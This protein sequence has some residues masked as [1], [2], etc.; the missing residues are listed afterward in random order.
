M[1]CYRL[2][3]YCLSVYGLEPSLFRFIF[4]RNQYKLSFIPSI[5]TMAVKKKIK[6]TI[7]SLGGSIIVPNHVDV[8]FLK[9]FRSFILDYL[10]DKER[11]LVLVCGGG[12]ICREYQEAAQQLASQQL[13]AQQSAS[14]TQTTAQRLVQLPSIKLSSE[15]L[16][17]IGIMSTRL[18]AELIRVLFKDVAYER[19]IYNPEERL[20]WI[21]MK[22]QLVIAAGYTPGWSTDYDAV[23]FAKELKA[24]MVINASNI[25]YVYDKDP[26]EFKEAKKVEKMSW[27]EYKT[28]VGGKFTPGMHAPFDPIASKVAS[29]EGIKVAVLHGQNLENMKKALRGK[30]FKGTVIG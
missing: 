4:N 26:R 13:A 18:N 10:K 24:D 19:V 9:E 3:V 25:D 30:V 14:S 29:Q 27:A 16:D 11:R 15:D 20:D 8:S 22:K 6:T 28:L 5:I 12:H 1:L 2:S 23:L 17:W 21:I 7:I